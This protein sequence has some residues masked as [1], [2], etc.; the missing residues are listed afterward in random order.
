[1]IE[2]HE[3]YELTVKSKSFIFSKLEQIEGEIIKAAN[4]GKQQIEIKCYMPQIDLI[5]NELVE[6]GYTVYQEDPIIIIK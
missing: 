2:S 5:T 6:C 4:E 1:M 3:A